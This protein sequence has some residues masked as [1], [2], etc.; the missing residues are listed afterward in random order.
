MNNSVGTVVVAALMV[1]S[2]SEAQGQDACAYDDPVYTCDA[3]G[4]GIN[5]F[6]A[7]D[8]IVNIGGSGIIDDADRGVRLDDDNT[9]TNDGQ[10]DVGDEGIDV[11]DSNTIVNNGLI[12]S[13]DDRGIKAR[14]DNEITNNGSI[15]ADK[16]GI[17][18]EDDNTII[19]NGSITSDGDRGI[20]VKDL[21]NITIGATGVI[22]SGDIGIKADNDNTITNA[23]LIDADGG[24]GDGIEVGDDNDITIGATGSII[25]E[26]RGIHLDGDDNTVTNN[27]SIL[28]EHDGIDG[29][30]KDRATIVNN[31]VIESTEKKA[32]ELGNDDDHVTNNGQLI[33]SDD[34]TV[35]LG[36]GDD[37]FV[38]QA[39]ADVSGEV[40]MG[41]DTDR[42]E[43][44]FADVIG[45]TTFRSLEDEEN[46]TAGSAAIL[47][48]LGGD[49]YILHT[50]SPT[51]LASS[52][53]MV[54]ALTHDL[55][56][57]LLNFRGEVPQA[58][59]V[60]KSTNGSNPWWVMGG[61]SYQEDV[62]H[63]FSQQHKN[64]T[65]GKDVRSF[66]I[67]FGYDNA[68]ADMIG[69]SQ[70]VDQQ[71]LYVGATKF[72]QLSDNLELKG[73]AI[74]GGISARFDGSGGTTD[75]RGRFGS[76]AGRLNYVTT[77]SGYALG[78]YAGYSG[79]SLGELSLGDI[80]FDSDNSQTFF[81][82]IDMRTPTHVFESGAGMN[83]VFGLGFQSGNAGT[84]A[85]SAG[86]TT[87]NFDGADTEE[88]F[89]II[90]VDF[91]LD[92]I[93]AS[94]RFRVSEGASAE[95][96]LWIRTEF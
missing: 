94:L 41:G 13:A 52:G 59:Q 6:N 65:F 11:G 67:F 82:G 81:G 14:D 66:N 50:G 32:I 33:S 90:G 95:T 89:G 56:R 28:S 3:T 78:S 15:D 40:N 96:S 87:I 31:G 43:V 42:L 79:S 80:T 70:S 75:E 8:Q 36:D 85:M 23:G 88:Q 39:N 48:G 21:N 10:I 69:N 77:T 54:G 26:R 24:D 49:D 71:M 29:E 44:E 38:W 76:V 93:A 17:E 20:E 18:A 7:D 57:R 46:I 61:V 45:S 19:N 63:G 1:F 4:D 16:P 86:G 9:I 64:L 55:T 34:T 60:S 51:V 84:V 53:S 22:G 5:E 35:N 73:L 47:E 37:T 92:A 62:G 30:G 74:L 25:A 58:A 83:A 91:S 72:V 12:T 68:T 2:T 27:G